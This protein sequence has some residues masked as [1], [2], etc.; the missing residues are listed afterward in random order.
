[1]GKDRNRI[2][3]RGGGMRRKLSDNI[4]FAVFIRAVFYAV[5]GVFARPETESVVM[6]CCDNS[7]LHAGGFEC[8]APLVA[9]ELCWI[10]YSRESVPCP[11]SAPV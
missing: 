3:A 6:F 7:S 1:M 11:H 8:F 4:A 9:V 2:S 10:E 5:V